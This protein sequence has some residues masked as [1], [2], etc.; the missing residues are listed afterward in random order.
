MVGDHLMRRTLASGLRC[1]LASGLLGKAFCPTR[2]VVLGR[3]PSG[4]HDDVILILIDVIGATSRCA[5][6]RR[7]AGGVITTGRSWFVG[8]FA[9]G[10]GGL[11]GERDNG[12]G[13]RVGLRTRCASSTGISC[14]FGSSF[15]AVARVG[16]CPRT[17]DGM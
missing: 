13:S 10:W 7:R 8:Q 14:R 5:G 1:T 12:D 3:G 15:T 2:Q 17:A 9:T 4:G 6:G 16:G 11:S